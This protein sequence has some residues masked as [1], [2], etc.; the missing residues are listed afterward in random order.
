MKYYKKTFKLIVIIL[1]FLQLSCK[2]DVKIANQTESQTIE[3]VYEG[4]ND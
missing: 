1:A 4:C 2:N 3:S